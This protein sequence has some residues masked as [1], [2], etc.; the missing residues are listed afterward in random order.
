VRGAALLQVRDLVAGYGRATVLDG[1]SLDIE[2]KAIT[3]VLGP[4]G[5]GKSTLLNALMGDV[6]ARAGAVRLGGRAMETL[7]IEE[8]VAHGMCLV[9]ETRALFASLSIEDNLL[10]GS[11]RRRRDSESRDELNNVYSRFPRLRERRRQ[12]AGT[13]SGGERQMLAIGRALMAKPRLLMLDEPSLGLAPLVVKEIMAIVESLRGEG[14]SVLLVEQNAKA[15]LKISDYGYVLENGA[16]SLEG[17]S[18]T[19]ASDA[20]VTATYLGAI[21]SNRIVDAIIERP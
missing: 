7:D 15:A 21:P 12:L 13:L 16:I 3:T 2:A 6:R 19:L 1:I 20:R 4:N 18:E 5:A 9:P 8:R 10:L 14:V 17:R 11:W